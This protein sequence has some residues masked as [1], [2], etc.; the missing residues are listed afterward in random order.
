M[1]RILLAAGL[2]LSVLSP[3]VACENYGEVLK[4][5]QYAR[6]TSQPS[7]QS[8][9]LVIDGEVLT[10]LLRTIQGL[11]MVELTADKAIV[12]QWKEGAFLALSN[13]GCVTQIYQFPIEP[14]QQL[15]EMVL[16]KPEADQPPKPGFERL[17]A[18]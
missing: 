10:T 7:D 2:C 13:G 6:D 16:G 14:W 18:A 17:R 9:V 11:F 3:A 1:R 15:M 4:R 5:A 12:L 8:K